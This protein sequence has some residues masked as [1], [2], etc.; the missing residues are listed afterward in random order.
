MRY[1]V[2]E[3]LSDKAV[4]SICTAAYWLAA[5]ITLSVTIVGKLKMNA[6]DREGRKK[7]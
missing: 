2:A 6:E 7:K 5:S 4:E 1:M 3:I